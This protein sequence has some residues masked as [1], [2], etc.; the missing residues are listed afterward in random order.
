M[1]IFPSESFFMFM[2]LSGCLGLV[3]HTFNYITQEAEAG[4]LLWISDQ[5]G[6]Y[7]KLQAS[8]HCIVRSGLKNNNKYE[9]MLGSL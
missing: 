6:Q 8:Q 3:A 5:P 7:S 2:K 1:Y 4:G 9:D